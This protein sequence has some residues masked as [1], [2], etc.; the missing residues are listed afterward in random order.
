MGALLRGQIAEGGYTA[1]LTNEVVSNG[2]LMPSFMPVYLMTKKLVDEFTGKEHIIADAVVRRTAQ[3]ESFDDAMRFYN[4]APYH[5][6]VVE[7]SEASIVKRLL[8]RGRNDD[9][10]EKIHRRIGWYKEDVV[11]SLKVLEERGAIIHRID[12]E[13]DEQTIHKAIM[14][15]LGLSQ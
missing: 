8:A 3:A 15:A 13:P 7:L 14:S 2:K 12:G 9:T 1:E 4:R 6:V 11:P 10:E 5:V